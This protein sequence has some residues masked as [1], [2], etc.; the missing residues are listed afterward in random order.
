MEAPQQ[1][2]VFL[3]FSSTDIGGELPSGSLLVS[4]TGSEDMDT[5]PNSAS[6]YPGDFWEAIVVF[7]CMI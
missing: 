5:W 2:L 4:K 1:F 6:Y 7:I 3:T